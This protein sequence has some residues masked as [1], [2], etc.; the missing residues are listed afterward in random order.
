M[1]IAEPITIIMEPRAIV[2]YVRAAFGIEPPPVLVRRY[3][4]G[5]R[6]YRDARIPLRAWAAFEA[7]LR[8]AP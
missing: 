1:P 2:V 3:D 5:Q 7:E 6:A 8:R 4:K